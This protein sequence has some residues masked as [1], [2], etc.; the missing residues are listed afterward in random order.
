M[1]ITID[2]TKIGSKVAHVGKAVGFTVL[3]GLLIGAT[4][5]Q[6]AGAAIGKALKTAN[7]VGE[8]VASK[9]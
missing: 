9:K 1:Q 2:T 3:G 8:Q 5:V 7:A 6:G 4:K